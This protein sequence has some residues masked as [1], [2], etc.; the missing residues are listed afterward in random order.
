MAVERES[1]RLAF[2][3]ALQ[4]LPPRQRAVLILRDVLGW[5]AARG[6]RPARHVGGGGQQRAAA[7]PGHPGRTGPRCHRRPRRPVATSED[8]ALLDRYV[9]AFERY[10][11]EALVAL[12]HEDATLSMPPHP[13]WL[14]GREQVRRWW[15][16]HRA[17]CA[18][19]RLVPVAANGSPAVA[20]FR[21]DGAG[22]VEAF[23]LQ[24][25]D[26]A[27]GR[28]RGVTAFLEPR[29]FPLFSPLPSTPRDGR[30]PH[31]RTA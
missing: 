30:R 20:Q 15:C 21:P 29:L 10:D 31:L 3:A 11:I 27:D 1:I 24:V 25:L 28:I 19:S 13:L 16:E 4:H 6:G 26:V 5:T 23:A 14:E 2:V 18:G 17:A 8:R 12:L 7:G 22:S 9:D